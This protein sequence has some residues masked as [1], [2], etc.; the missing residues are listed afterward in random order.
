MPTTLAPPPPSTPDNAPRPAPRPDSRPDSLPDPLVERRLTPVVAGSTALRAARTPHLARRLTLFLI[1]LAIGAVLFLAL[2]PWRQ[3]VAGSGQ[4]TSFSP[5]SRP[6][7]VEAL[8]DGRIERWEVQEGE[9]V[10]VGQTLVVLDDI[11]SSYLDPAF[12]ARTEELRAARLAAAQLGVDAAR[13]ATAQAEQEV[14]AARAGV[15]NAAVEVETARVRYERAEALQDEGL[16]AVRDLESARLALRKAERDA[17]AAEADLRAAE[18][19]LERRRIA[20]AEAEQAIAAATADLDLDLGNARGRAEN[21]I[22]R[23]PV[24][25]TVVR[26]AEVGPGQAVKAGDPLATVVPDAPA[27]RAVELFVSDRDA[28]LIEP[29]REVRLQFAGLP[30]LVFSGAP[31][32]SVGAFAGRVAVVDAVDDGTGRFRLLVTPDSTADSDWPDASFLRQ[33][34]SVTGWVLLSEVPLGYELWRRM[35]GL[36]PEI[37]VK[38]SAPKAE[39]GAKPKPPAARIK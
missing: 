15:D 37:P 36:P 4:V 18:R 11:G 6:Q 39:D 7:T 24:S 23:A 38:S 13:Q 32:L 8:I 16:A 10:E 2:T 5:S 1:A 30:A 12:V 21:A 26:I 35:N 31:E 19:G 17:V 29:G 22:V 20:E 27:D 3:V 34:S 14:R 33:G 25:G 28:A 9:R